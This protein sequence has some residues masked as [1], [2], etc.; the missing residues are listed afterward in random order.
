MPHLHTRAR[1][2]THEHTH[3]HIRERAHTHTHKY[4]HMWDHTRE[5]THCDTHTHTHAYTRARAHT[6]TTHTYTRAHTHTHTHTHTHERT[7]ALTRAHSLSLSLFLSLSLSLLLARTHFWS[8]HASPLFLSAPRI[9]HCCFRVTS[10]LLVLISLPVAKAPHPPIALHPRPGRLFLPQLARFHEI[11]RLTTSSV[12][13]P[14]TSYQELTAR[15]QDRILHSGPL[16][17]S[18]TMPRRAAAP[19]G[20][21]QARFRRVE[22]CWRKL[23]GSARCRTCSSRRAARLGSAVTRPGRADSSGWAATV[24]G[25]W[26]WARVTATLIAAGRG[27]LEGTR[28]NHDG[29]AV[30]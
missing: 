3:E 8:A 5:Y 10:F 6:H 9:S 15:Y 19:S 1:T 17:G 25:R 26:R 28:N 7:D 13:R 11:S 18:R 12:S 2:Y 23:Y 14:I 30:L 16:T 4:T 20:S 22:A 21:D 27:K 24:V 29:G